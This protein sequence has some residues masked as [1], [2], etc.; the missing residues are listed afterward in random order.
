MYIPPQPL[1]NLRGPT[2]D[3]IRPSR[4]QRLN[5]FLVFFLAALM[6]SG[7]N[8]S[9]SKQIRSQVTY[10]GGFEKIHQNPEQFIGA[11]V[12]LGGKI[13]QTRATDTYSEIT[14]M[15]LPLDL[16]GVPHNLGITRGHYLL[17]TDQHLEPGQFETGI[18]LAVAT[19]LK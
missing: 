3:D 12:I 2:I 9:I 15:H 8:P 4:N 13:V 19:Y 6:L 14:V 16:A 1:L 7:C 10:T 17:Y 11:T 5:S 18:L